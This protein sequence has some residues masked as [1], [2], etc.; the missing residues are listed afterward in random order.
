MKRLAID[1]TKYT[2]IGL[3]VTFTSVFFMWLFIDIF[4]I[5]TPL[6]SSF[7]VVVLF[8][9]KFMAYNKVNLIHKQFIKYTVIQGGSGLLYIIGTWIL[10]DIMKLSTVFSS[11]L[12]VCCLF[13]LRFILFK[14]TKLT[15]R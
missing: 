10:I 6:A 11:T 8:F 14:L 2:V 1:F 15:V 5:H 3:F 4:G 13:L 7:L 12:A 9:M